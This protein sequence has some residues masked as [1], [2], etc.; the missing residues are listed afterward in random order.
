MTSSTA[1]L[2]QMPSR[3]SLGMVGVGAFGSFAIKHLRV[4]FRIVG[5]DPFADLQPLE[6]Q[7]G[8]SLGSL[9][10]AASCD[11]VVLSMPVQK[12][13]SVVRDIRP[14]LRQGSV[15]LDVCSVKSGP[16]AI[17]SE[18]PNHV[19]VVGTHPLFGPQ[20]GK[21]GIAGLSIA[22][23]PIRGSAWRLV[24][25]FFRDKLKLKVEV[26]TAEVHDRQM[27]QVQGLSH[28]ISRILL[29]MPSPPL[30]MTTTAFDHLRSMVELLSGDSDDLFHAICADNPYV[31]DVI[32]NFLDTSKN[33][34]E[35]FRSGEEEQTRPVTAGL[36]AMAAVAGSK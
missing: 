25:A 35:R 31:K 33:V 11:F 20:S 34:G 30:S 23:V 21:A 13:A 2:S 8:L 1:S 24:T 28:L 5:F 10:E 27:A 7:Y 19:Q 15:V 12:L 17:L 16:A 3:P 29:S 6:G 9:A 36:R 26:T 4:H 18:L 14:Y 32:R 22:V